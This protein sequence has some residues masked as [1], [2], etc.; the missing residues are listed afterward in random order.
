VGTEREEELHAFHRANERTRGR[1]EAGLCSTFPVWAPFPH[2]VTKQKVLSQERKKRAT[3]RKKHKY[4]NNA[5][6]S[7]ALSRGL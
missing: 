5:P 7:A 2:L 6:A 4:V 3:R 1:G